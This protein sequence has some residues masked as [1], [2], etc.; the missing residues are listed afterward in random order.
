MLW[1]EV[2]LSG[3]DDGL[4]SQEIV[5]IVALCVSRVRA[6]AAPEQNEQPLG[7]APSSTLVALS[8]HHSIA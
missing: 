5:A 4:G 6:A 3:Q 7:S 8:S 1:P 2:P